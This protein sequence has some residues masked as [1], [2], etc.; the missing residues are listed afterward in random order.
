MLSFE[1]ELKNYTNSIILASSMWEKQYANGCSDPFW[2]DGCNLNLLR[3]HIIYSKRK[4]KELCEQNH[5]S[6]SE[7]YYLPIPPYLNNNYFA[8]PNSERAKKIVKNYGQCA[9]TEKIIKK[10]FNSKQLSFI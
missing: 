8:N 5:I 2:P 4:I 9:N 7:E 3:N 1:K 6:I 10:D